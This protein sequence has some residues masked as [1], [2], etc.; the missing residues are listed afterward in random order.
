MRILF[1][2]KKSEYKKPFGAL[3]Q[4]EECVLNL[5]VPTSCLAKKV[6]IKLFSDESG[7]ET[8]VSMNKLSESDG[9][10]TFTGS[11]SL[12]ATGLYFYYFYLECMESS[13]SLYKFGFNDTNIEEGE[14]WQITCYEKDFEVPKVFCGKVMYQIFPDRFAVSGSDNTFGKMEPYFIHENRE[15]VPCFMPDANGKI[16]NCDFYGGN[17]KGIEEKL[18]Y[19]KELGVSIIYLNPIFK[20]YSNH[21]YDTCDYKTLD[22]MLGSDEDFISLCQ[23]AHVKGIKIILDGVFSHTGSRSIYFDKNHE[24][25]TGVCSN[26]DSPY[27]D[28]FT[29]KNFPHEYDTWWGIETLPCVNEMSE[30]FLDYIIRDEDSV[31]A[32]WLKM[33]ADGFRLDVADELPDE[34]IRLLRMRVKECKKESFVLG[35]VWED[36]SNKISYGVRR[37]YFSNS[38]LDSVMNYVFKDAIISFVK[39]ETDKK[40]FENEI[41]TIVENYPRDAVNSLMNCLSTHDTERILTALSDADTSM[42]KYEKS[43]FKLMPKLKS[44]AFERL[45]IAVLLQFTLPGTA[46]IYY[47]DEMAMEGFGDPFCRGFFTDKN[48]NNELFYLIKALAKLKNEYASLSVGDISFVDRDVLAFERTFESEKVTIVI[49]TEGASY[50]CGSRN[51]LLSHNVSKI[52]DKTFINQM[53]FM[54]YKNG[55]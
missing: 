40:H 45:M 10:D 2:S 53:G 11:F 51:I 27:K 54:V 24:F 22:P 25:G 31:I 14:K 43:A 23:R 5:K 3:R 1:D 44:K 49:N 55:E 28:W 8:L 12:D 46:S 48:K 17:L 16:L 30:G 52:G 37:K 19:L 47:G 7:E 21:R 13:F 29:F 41:M 20:A 39:G 6:T 9:Y 18:D 15:D 42:S 4:G 36:A 32:H 33:G 34:F 50:E 26:N 38:E 35:E